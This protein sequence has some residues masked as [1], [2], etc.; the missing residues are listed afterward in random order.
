MLLLPIP[1]PLERRGVGEAKPVRCTEEPPHAKG[2][3]ALQRG[4][5]GLLRDGEQVGLGPPAGA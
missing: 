3:Q 2:G 1:A 4:R 5:R